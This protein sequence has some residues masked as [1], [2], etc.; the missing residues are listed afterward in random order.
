MD[1]PAET[2]YKIDEAL[3]FLAN[4]TENVR[5]L[6]V[7]G[8][9]Y[10]NFMALM[11]SCTRHYDN[12]E[13]LQQFVTKL[14]EYRPITCRAFELY[15]NKDII[16]D[17][18]DT[19][20]Y[21]DVTE[22]I[23]DI[24]L[25]QHNTLNES[26]EAK[27]NDTIFE[28]T[29]IRQEIKETEPTNDA[30][31]EKDSEYAKLF[32]EL[33]T[34]FTKYGLRPMSIKKICTKDLGI[35]GITR[36]KKDALI[37]EIITSGESQKLLKHLR[38]EYGDDETEEEVEEENTP[39]VNDVVID[40]ASKGNIDLKA[41]ADAI[42]AIE[43]VENA[44]LTESEENKLKNANVEEFDVLGIFDETDE[45]NSPAAN[46]DIENIDI[47]TMTSQDIFELLLELGVKVPVMQSKELY[48]EKFNEYVK[49]KD[50]NP[51]NTFENDLSD[52][53]K[54]KAKYPQLTTAIDAYK[55]CLK[56]GISRD[57]L[58][59]KRPVEYYLKKLEEHNSWEI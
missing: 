50:K 48:I 57:D 12:I 53:E 2:N 44:L 9:R 3:N 13:P 22:D 33:S 21:T 20:E 43:K 45:E 40:E 55:Q 7:I 25:K 34:T 35:E 4:P 26:R 54:L 29:D 11:L 41:I 58:E 15:L 18:G 42:D 27:K 38:K 47:E 14:V 37:E 46:D 30:E 10:P 32:D 39:A 19:L 59:K 5:E 24:P 17:D 49:N 16:A 6:S 1:K 56:Q 51:P 28:E 8:A 36:I 31:I 23:A 52:D